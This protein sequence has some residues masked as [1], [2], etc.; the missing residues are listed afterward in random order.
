MKKPVMVALKDE[1]RSQCRLKLDIVIQGETTKG[2]SKSP[3]DGAGQSKTK[4]EKI[5]TNPKQKTTNQI[6]QQSVMNIVREQM[7]ALKINCIC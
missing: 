5:K 2:I 6:L 3:G 1:K 4:V 7:Y